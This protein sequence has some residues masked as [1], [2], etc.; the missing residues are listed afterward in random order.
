MLPPSSR[1]RGFS[2]KKHPPLPHTGARGWQYYSGCPFRLSRG[3]LCSGQDFQ[4]ELSHKRLKPCQLTQRSQVCSLL[5]VWSHPGVSR[6]C[7]SPVCDIRG[8]SKIDELKSW[9]SRLSKMLLPSKNKFSH[10]QQIRSKAVGIKWKKGLLHSKVNGILYLL[11]YPKS[12]S[13]S[14]QNKSLTLKLC[15]SLPCFLFPIKKSEQIFVPPPNS[16]SFKKDYK[17]WKELS[18][19]VILKTTSLPSAS[20]KQWQQPLPSQM[21][22]DNPE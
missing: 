11:S 2:S 3:R 20:L 12:N 10:L 21:A 15:L 18:H 5:E 8:H 22:P 14:L 7:P 17:T 13:V 9:K 1:W 4:Q 16:C 6:S 19:L